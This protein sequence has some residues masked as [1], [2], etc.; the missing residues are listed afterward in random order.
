MSCWPS[1]V[2][3]ITQMHAPHPPIHTE[4]EVVRQCGNALMLGSLSLRPPQLMLL[5]FARPPQL[6][7]P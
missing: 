4:T 6:L 2:Y 1:L 5:A 3:A 7:E